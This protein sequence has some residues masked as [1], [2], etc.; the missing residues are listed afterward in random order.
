MDFFPKFI[1]KFCEIFKDCL[2]ITVLTENTEPTKNES[3]SNPDYTLVIFCDV[4]S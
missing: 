3:K 4:I 1:H 2:S